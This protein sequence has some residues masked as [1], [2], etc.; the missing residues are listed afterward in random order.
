MISYALCY[1]NFIHKQKQLSNE[2]GSAILF[3][4]NLKNNIG[5]IEKTISKFRSNNVRRYSE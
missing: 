1:Q 3:F 2:K 4:N 5:K